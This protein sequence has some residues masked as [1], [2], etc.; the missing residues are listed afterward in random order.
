MILKERENDK[1]EEAGV[2]TTWK[3][4]ELEG[5]LRG[6]CECNIFRL[7]FQLNC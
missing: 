1:Y 4:F 3:G 6:I 7:K 2:L 5:S